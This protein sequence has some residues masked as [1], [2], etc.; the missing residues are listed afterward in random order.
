MGSVFSPWYARARRGAVMPAAENH[1]ALNVSLYGTVRRWAMT[2]R[3]RRALRRDPDAIAIGPSRAAW[4]GGTLRFTI[5]E[6]GCPMPRSIR[7]EVLVRPRA[8]TGATYA[9]D[10]AG[11]H[12]W[13]PLA[14]AADV[15]VAL[16]RPRLRW[17]GLGYLDRNDGD[18]ALE[19][20]FRCW[21][22]CRAPRR[23][24]TAIIYDATG[25]D[26]VE[27]RLALAIDESGAVTPL[28]GLVAATLPPTWWR[29]SRATRADPGAQ[30]I[31]RETL[32]DSP[33][34][35]RSL[36]ATRIGGETVTAVHESLD[37]DRFTRPSCQLML[38]F[39][40][41]RQLFA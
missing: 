26:G 30:V 27:R 8:L 9:L 28:D 32:Q 19:R 4:D 15:A 35:A 18:R 1:A 37:L 11:R 36:L 2:E 3:G 25:R 40:V 39:R 14:P 21:H 33:F 24:G 13:S 10:A 5:S 6:R 38:P 7:G 29:V 22:W 17:D 16:D 41:P 31:V 23:D 34:Y 20:D 12:R